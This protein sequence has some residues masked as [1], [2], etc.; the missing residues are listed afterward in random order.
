[1]MTVAVHIGPGDYH[2]HDGDDDDDVDDHS[3]KNDKNNQNP[4]G[5]RPADEDAGVDVAAVAL[6]EAEVGRTCSGQHQSRRR[7][8]F[9]R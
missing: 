2:H 5:E 4:K 9:A 1:M 7:S 3:D 6:L 8:T